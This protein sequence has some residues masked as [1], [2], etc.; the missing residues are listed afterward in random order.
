V[1]SFHAIWPDLQT[2]VKDEKYLGTHPLEFERRIKDLMPS[3]LGEAA[4]Q[5]MF[6]DMGDALTQATKAWR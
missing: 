3:R 5:K 1:T 4:I 2:K 6:Q